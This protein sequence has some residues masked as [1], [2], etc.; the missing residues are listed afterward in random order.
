M[1]AAKVQRYNCCD[2][3]NFVNLNTFLQ[4]IIFKNQNCVR[5]EGSLFK[6]PIESRRPYPKGC[7][8]L[9]GSFLFSIGSL[10]DQDK[11]V[12]NSCLPQAGADVGSRWIG[13]KLWVSWPKAESGSFTGSLS[14]GEALIASLS[15]Q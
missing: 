1:Y 5:G 11:Y 15:T 3:F 13:N 2:K 7:S 12:I 10:S 6:S 8:Y 14:L 9:G 4:N